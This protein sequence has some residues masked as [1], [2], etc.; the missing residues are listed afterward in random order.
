ML[1][2]VQPE[3][4]PLSASSSSSRSPVVAVFACYD[5]GAPLLTYLQLEGNSQAVQRLRA[6]AA[7]CEDEDMSLRLWPEA[8]EHDRAQ[9]LMQLQDP[10][11]LRE[12]LTAA[13]PDG[14]DGDG[15]GDRDK[16][17]VSELLQSL[18]PGQLPLLPEEAPA[19]YT[20]TCG[21]YATQLFLH[22]LKGLVKQQPQDEETD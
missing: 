20:E 11:R 16:W 1:D 3:Y 8:L 6:I 22:H 13:L 5:G 12:A 10:E 17:A 2:F 7:T 14:P 21:D 4:P 18:L 19:G 9:E 15:W